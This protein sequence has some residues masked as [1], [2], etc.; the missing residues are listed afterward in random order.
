MRKQAGGDAQLLHRVRVIGTQGRPGS[1]QLQ[2]GHQRRLHPGAS[3]SQFWQAGAEFCSC[4]S[5]Q[6]TCTAPPMEA[7]RSVAPH[8]LHAPSLSLACVCLLRSVR[9]SAS[10]CPTPVSAG[11]PTQQHSTEQSSRAGRQRRHPR[12]EGSDR[13]TDRHSALGSGGADGSFWPPAART[14]GARL[15]SPALMSG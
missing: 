8:S 15:A 5:L 6:V 2:G 10:L 12:E 14:T 1:R 11:S 9:D 3:P 4:C 13:Q 7:A